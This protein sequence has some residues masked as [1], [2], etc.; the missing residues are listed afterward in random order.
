MDTFEWNWRSSC[1]NEPMLGPRDWSPQ[2]EAALRDLHAKEALIPEEMLL[3]EEEAEECPIF[4][5]DAIRLGTAFVIKVPTQKTHEVVYVG[6]KGL[7]MMSGFI[8][9]VFDGYFGSVEEGLKAK[10]WIGQSREN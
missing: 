8:A 5:Y 3:T 7:V 4:L 1:V 10:V 9:A 2:V 6:P